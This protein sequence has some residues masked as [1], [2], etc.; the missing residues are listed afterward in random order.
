MPINKS[1]AEDYDL[2]KVYPL[3]SLDAFYE[4]LTSFTLTDEEALEYMTFSAKMAR[5]RFS[6]QEEM[7]SL[8]ADF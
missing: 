6:S 1:A 2:N 3:I 5:I 4:N 8:K 7:L